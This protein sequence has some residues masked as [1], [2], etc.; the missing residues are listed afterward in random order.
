MAAEGARDGR[1]AAGVG[2]LAGAELDSLEALSAKNME[3][4][5]H[6]GAFV[7][8]VVLLVADGTFYIHGLLRGAAGAGCCSSWFPLLGSLDNIP[9]HDGREGNWMELSV[10]LSDGEM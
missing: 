9:C 3:T 7:V 8:L 6:P 10:E 4:L 2:E 5:Q 1:R